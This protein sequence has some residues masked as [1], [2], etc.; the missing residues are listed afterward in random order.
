[1][2]F[3]WG[4]RRAAVALGAERPA[5][6]DDAEDAPHNRVAAEEYRA[7]LAREEEAGLFE[8]EDGEEERVEVDAAAEA[9]DSLAVRAPPGRDSVSCTFPG[10][11]PLAAHA[12]PRARGAQL[13]NFNLTK[14][15]AAALAARGVSRLFPIQGATFKPLSEGRDLIGR[16][17]TGTGKTLAF[18]LPIIEKLI[19]VRAAAARRTPQKKC[20]QA[21]EG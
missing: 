2:H 6:A 5:Q 21:D 4:V 20:T 14:E 8:E 9:D 1:M 16:A 18:S 13:A 15:T 3:F 19:R 7:Q 11:R 12:A 17:R 10:A